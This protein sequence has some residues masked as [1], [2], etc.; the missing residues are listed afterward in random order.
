MPKTID[1]YKILGLIHHGAMGSI[2]KAEDTRTG[3]I[4]ALKIP[5]NEFGMDTVCFDAYRIEKG[6][7][8]RLDDPRFIK[9]Y[10][11]EPKTNH[12]IVMEYVEGKD[13]RSLFRGRPLPFDRVREIFV[14]ICKAVVFFQNKGI[15]HFDLKP[16]N[17]MLPEAGGIK[18]VDFGLACIIGEQDIITEKHIGPKGTPEYISPEQVLGIRC[19][20]RSDIYAVG[21]MLYEALTGRLPFSG[22]GT[23]LAKKKL[24]EGP[25]PPKAF[26]PDFSPHLQEIILKALEPNPNNRYQ[27]IE[28]LCNDLQEPSK[29][30]LTER[31]HRT[32]S[33][34]SRE[35]ILSLEGL[36]EV[37]AKTP[38]IK[39]YR[40]LAAFF[41]GRPQQRVLSE[42]VSLA[43]ERDAVVDIVL[44]TQGIMDIEYREGEIEDVIAY[45][46]SELLFDNEW[47]LEFFGNNGIE[48]TLDVIA[49][50]PESEILRMADK[51]KVDLIVTSERERGRLSKVLFRSM[52]ARIADKAPC[53]VL[54][55][56]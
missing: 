47:V 11:V 6:I 16:E 7:W 30:L 23:A 34:I 29:V 44:I 26:M 53:S 4:V 55:I 38:F 13:L 21:V 24:S 3:K 28:D 42:I 32:K 18:I 15:V 43:R 39:K 2:Y 50:D 56:K 48:A 10:E 54:V 36:G 20:P 46:K 41:D 5:C 35:D 19:D 51:K 8:K 12:Y 40:I 37:R 1:H 27:K 25:I 52:S 33:S 17:V 22:K 31:A 49:G 14:E 45:L 9:F